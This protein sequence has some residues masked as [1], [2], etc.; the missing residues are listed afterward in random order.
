MLLVQIQKITLLVSAKLFWAWCCKE[1]L[2]YG[3]DGG[4]VVSMLAFYNYDPSLN[5]AES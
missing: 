5:S 4:Q 1:I 3:S 2:V